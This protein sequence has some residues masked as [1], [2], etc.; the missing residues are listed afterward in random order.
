MIAAAP[1]GTKGE[2]EALSSSAR[3]WPLT[4]SLYSTRDDG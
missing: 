3:L 2:F 1:R 4:L